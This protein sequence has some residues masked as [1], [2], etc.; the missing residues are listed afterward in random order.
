MTKIKRGFK[1]DDLDKFFVINPDNDLEFLCNEGGDYYEW[2]EGI[3]NAEI[4]T[5]EELKELLNDPE[6]SDIEVNVIAVKD[7]FAMA[8]EKPED[9]DIIIEN[10]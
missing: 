7:A 3:D 9:Y 2:R 8:N 6:N 5:R 10:E 1:T 4:F